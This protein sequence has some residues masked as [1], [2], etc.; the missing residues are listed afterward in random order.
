[1]KSLPLILSFLFLAGPF[2]P[3][4][5]EPTPGADWPHWR[6]P[7]RNGISLEADWLTNEATAS[8]R[9][10]WKAAVGTGFSAVSVSGGLLYTMGNR[11]ETDTVWCLDAAT[12][13]LIWRHDYACA[14]DPLYYEGGPGGT[15]TVAGGRVFTFSKKGHAHCLDAATGEV[16]WSR[17]LVKDHDLKLPEWSFAG[18]P[19]VQDDRVFLNA[20]SA[21]ICLDRATGK[22]IWKSGPEP[23]GYAT[24]VPLTWK[25][26]PAVILFAAGAVVAVDP[27]DGKLL[28]RH[29]WE[30][31]RDVNAAD[32]ILAGDGRIF[33][34]SASGGALLDVSG[35]QPVE[36]WRNRE[37]R[38]YFNTC[39]LIDGHLYGLDGTTHKPNRLVCLELATGEVKWAEEGFGSGGWM[40]ADGKLILCDQ[41]E[42]IV[43]AA[44][45]E[46][47]RL[48]LREQ[49]LGGKCWT[50]PVLANGRIYCRNAAGDLVAVDLPEPKNGG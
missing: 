5:A 6:G 48:I 45:P 2:R 19:L 20:G 1:M 44:D 35:D 25:G 33:V 22:T 28:W 12:G 40:A 4:N 13:E 49:V 37:M 3:A 15:P 29:P 42:L 16:V 34:S 11:D 46:Q 7:D 26:R 14:L 31:G 41:G 18:S 32:P 8:P 24:P 23:P 36:V 21:G 47:F 17:D 50:M 9:I 10:L 27:A 30:T 39:V 43:V 38:N